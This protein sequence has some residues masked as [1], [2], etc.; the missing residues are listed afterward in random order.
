VQY[1]AYL[2]KTGE[3]IKEKVSICI[4]LNVDMKYLKVR[5]SL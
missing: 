1:V 3:A 2:E 4:R 5:L